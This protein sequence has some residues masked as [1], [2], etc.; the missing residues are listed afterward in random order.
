MF[1]AALSADGIQLVAICVH[2]TISVHIRKFY[3]YSY[4]LYDIHICILCMC[5]NYT[6]CNIQTERTGQFG[7][8]QKL[9]KWQ[10]EFKPIQMLN[11]KIK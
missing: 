8:Q 2:I 9:N 11:S 1:E 5:A 7:W 10:F 3:A 6:Y 4:E